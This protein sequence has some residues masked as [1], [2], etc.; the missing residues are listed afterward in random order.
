MAGKKEKEVPGKKRTTKKTQGL[1]NQGSSTTLE[2]GECSPSTPSPRANKTR[3]QKGD[4]LVPAGRPK[5]LKKK[6]TE[7][8]IS[9]G[10]KHTSVRKVSAQRVEQELEQEEK[11]VR[12]DQMYAWF[13][14]QQRKDRRSRRSRSRSRESGSH[15]S[16]RHRSTHH[17]GSRDSRS[18]SRS[19][20]GSRRSRYSRRSSRSFSKSTSSSRLRKGKNI[21]YPQ[22]LVGLVLRGVRIV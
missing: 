1:T 12:F 8:D 22:G 5:R 2:E 6:P 19:S 18:P 4:F 15:S 20:G 10:D 17:K 9:T 13:Q 11:D 7:M 21:R 16:S 3:K 14:D